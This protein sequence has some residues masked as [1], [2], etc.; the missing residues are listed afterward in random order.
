[1]RM[2]PSIGRATRRA[3]W[4]LVVA[5]VAGATALPAAAGS[6]A[7]P[8]RA[9]QQGIA[10]EAAVEPVDG[11]EL[12]EGGFA[13]VRLQMTDAATGTPLA[14]LAPGAWMDRRPASGA[15]PGE[16]KKRVE[17]FVGGS[18]LSRPT[19]DLNVYYVV[20]LNEEPS[21]TVVDPLFGYGNS[22]LLALVPLDGPGS[23]W[24]LAADGRRLFVAVPAAGHVAVVDTEAWKVV[25]RLPTGPAPHR[26]VLQPDGRYLWAAYGGAAGQPSG[27][28]V[29]DARALR[30][31]ADLP[32]GRGPHDIAL[33]DDSRFA[34]VTN[35]DDGT[36][37]VLDVARL[38]KVRDVAVGA[39]PVSVAWSQ[40]AG[41][42]FV[43]AAGDGTLVAVLP[44]AA[45]PAARVQ[46]EAG[47]DGGKAGDLGR[48][49][50][51]PGGR[52]GFVPRPD[53]NKIY[54]LDAASR[55]I[56][57][58]G[59]VEAGPDQITFTDELAY[60]RHRGSETVLMIPLEAVGQEGRPL[61]VIDFPGGQYPPG[62][63]PLPTP[64]DGI[65][66]A[67]GAPAVLVA[68]PRDQAIFFYKEGMAAPM[69]HFRTYSRTPRAV[70]VVDRSLRE[71][72]TGRYETV[73]QLA[74]AGTY[75]LAVLV[76][77][78]Q[79]VQCFPITVAADP[80]R[81]AR[82]R[83]LRI[84][85][86]VD[87]QEIAAGADTRVRFKIADPATGT[88]RAGLTD[89]QALT[90]L[91]PGVWQRRHPAAEVGPGLYEIHFTP[92]EAGLYYVFVEVPSAGLALQSS[93]ALT[94]TAR[95]APAAADGQNPGGRR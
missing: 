89:V 49:R 16:C 23:D 42:A 37:S 9:V 53:G 10:V 66:Q 74:G 7:A 48:L 27:V 25:D 38:A 47:P 57:Q 70:L 29:L 26:V 94:L 50:F 34:F 52:F 56:V 61:P 12:V 82:R 91:S 81:A 93:P 19:L 21:L 84:E 36:V 59:T 76:N 67:P 90:F 72:A 41:T 58:S 65:V 5:S 18:L 85:P 24:A 83:P 17:A 33:S 64:A 68:N 86:F 3:A 4:A 45:E 62:Q 73:V 87:S 71:V 92:P 35:E 63:V 88:P 95:E 79:V 13:R 14:R 46:V 1:M 55:R 15:T 60:V 51:A 28:T 44:D 20:V 78:P 11:N 43:V 54:V 6:P 32:T 22:K 8:Q 31:V 2:N 69:G 80:T 40:P 75:D 77:N 30:K 39:R